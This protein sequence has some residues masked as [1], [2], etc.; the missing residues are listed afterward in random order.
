MKSFRKT[1][2]VLILAAL[3]LCLAACGGGKVEPTPEENWAAATEKWVAG[4]ELLFELRVKPNVN[5]TL[6]EK[7][8]A[9]C[10]ITTED[11]AK[12]LVH[13][14]GL[15]YGKDFE[16]MLKY[17]RSQYPE[18]LSYGKTSQNIIVVYNSASVEICSKINDVTCL[19]T[20]GTDVET[21]LAV[22]SNVMIKV[23]GADYVPLD[24]TEDS[25]VIIG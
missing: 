3:I 14:Q 12:V 8:Y 21:V 13:I 11:G 17:F 20:T 6:E 22:F 23:A 10:E 24:P 1:V 5:Y 25:A 7:S 4:T 15:A 18:K 16:N 2:S 9:S 19:T